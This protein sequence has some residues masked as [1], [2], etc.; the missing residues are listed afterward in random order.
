M[1]APKTTGKFATSEG[2]TMDVR[3]VLGRQALPDE[4]T[5]GDASV[6]IAVLDG[7]VDLSHP[8]FA[9]ADLTTIDTL[10]QEEA[11]DGLMSLHGTHVASLIFGQPGSPV[12]GLA[13]RCRGLLLP[14]FPDGD[15][16][17][18]SQLD[19]ARAIERAV[20]EGAHLINISGGE[21]APSGEPS[22]LLGRALRQC[23]DNGVLVIAAVG[24]DGCDCVQVP[25]AFPSVIAV[26]ATSPDGVPLEINN[27]GDAYRVNGVLAPGQHIRGAA[28][29]GASGQLSGSSF[30]TPIVAG[31]A[32]L[33]LAAQR[34][35]GAD[36]D[37]AAVRE[38]VIGTATPCDT[39]V[40]P[41]RRLN[42]ANAYD[43]ITQ[44]RN[45]AVTTST[46]PS[47][48]ESPAPQDNAPPPMVSVEATAE[49]PT[50]AQ[51]P[52]SEGVFAAAG[53]SPPAATPPAA[54]A[55]AARG[56]SPSCGGDA[57]C[58]CNG[59]GPRPLVYAIGKIGFDFRTEARRD[60][61]LQQMHAYKHPGTEVDT[62]SPPNPYNPMQL[63]GY[64]AENPWASDKVTWTLT[65]DRT[66]LYALEAELPVGMDW[67]QPVLEHV[68]N[69]DDA[70]KAAGDAGEL[71]RIISALSHP[72]VSHVYR[73]FREAIV[74]QALAV[75]DEAYISRVSVPGLLTGR[76][77]R[78]F[79]GQVVPVVEVK[80]RGVHTWN[81][82]A[83]VNAAVQAVVAQAEADEKRPTPDPDVLRQ[84]VQ[85]LLD[86][87]YY[88]F[89]NLGQT[90]A[91]R[92][93]NY[94]GTNAFMIT[95]EFEQGLLSGAYVPG[96]NSGF[97]T[98]D[99]VSVSKSPYDR[100]D[101]DCW[102]VVTTFFDPEDDDRARVSY[103]FTIDVS[104][105]LP[106]SLAP[107]HRFLGRM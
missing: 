54:A 13:P 33:L 87:I 1:P 78:L 57:S 39:A 59:G 22:A 45:T 7:P 50:P 41:G 46:Q 81:E 2:I 72:P 90:P 88:Q 34:R 44:G 83:L 82:A 105:E 77:V 9:G 71:A 98:L 18:V 52:E 4:H 70:K 53:A 104:D 10:V 47:Q 73:L 5:I 51:T 101:S 65:M 24:N 15:E 27:W 64:L 61:F 97:Y 19:L 66:P 75:D 3:S 55:P 8:C 84:N 94:A 21:R 58:G 11:G 12:T 63:S 100:V 28:P 38:A 96:T 91:D 37:P 103:L 25:A 32:G 99:T 102:D 106:V 16:R 93:L 92:A 89:R 26:G 42:F 49:T 80:S 14:V 56:V 30:A 17:K 79:S 36:P 107:A 86:K 40:P 23:E 67:H 31:V 20:T 29:G 85:A 69:A 95:K 35:A 43:V 60:S 76:T 48:A 68:G 74:G 6:C 62:F